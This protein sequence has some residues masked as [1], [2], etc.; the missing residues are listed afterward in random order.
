MELFYDP[1]LTTSTQKLPEAESHHCMRVLRKKAGEEIAITNGKNLWVKAK[2]TQINNKTCAFNI[3]ETHT[4]NPPMYETIL[5]IAPTK[6]FDR[7]E[8]LIEKCVELGITKVEFF[9][10][11]HSERRI[12]KNDRLYKKAVSAMKQSGQLLMPQWTEIS[13]FSSLIDNYQSFNGQKFIP[14]QDGKPF[15]EK[16]A[17]NQSVIMVIGPEGGFS[18]QELDEAYQARFTPVSLNQNRLRTETAGLMAAFAMKMS[19][20]G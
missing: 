13:S 6:N 3:F 17:Y 20:Q 11:F 18:D 12:L 5:A 9:T 10:G 4:I 19:N 8:W 2:L 14:V 1:H 15:L 16:A 7:M